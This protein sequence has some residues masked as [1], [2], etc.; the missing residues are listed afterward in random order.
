VHHLERAA[1][2]SL[3]ATA[4][5]TFGEEIA[6]RA[7]TSA[8]AGVG[9]VRIRFTVVGDTGTAFEGGETV[10]TVQTDGSGVAT[11]PALVAGEKAGAFVVRATVVGRDLTAA[12]WDGVVTVRTA[13][14]L[15]LVQGEPLVCA[16]GGEFAERIAVDATRDGA[17]AAKVGATVTLIKSA[18][19]P[20]EN[21]KGPYF[22]DAEGEPVRTL[23]LTADADGVLA[24]PALFAGDAA[25]TYLLLVDT[26]GAGRLTVELTVE[27]AEGGA[28]TGE[29][30]GT[31]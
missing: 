7:A 21:D 8:G 10:A 3:T 17:P 1:G 25:G 6:A 26:P 28:T 15:T 14:K 18:A 13:D 30:A 27:A 31:A 29:V 22:K 5:T 24:L 20:T 4:G 9:K 2:D 16:V 23:E 19:D 11:A 12:E